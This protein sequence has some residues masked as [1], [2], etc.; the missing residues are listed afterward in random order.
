M[1]SDRLHRHDL[2]KN[3]FGKA[4]TSADSTDSMLCLRFGLLSVLSISHRFPMDCGL[5]AD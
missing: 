2:N 1:H 4:V 3:A 5:T